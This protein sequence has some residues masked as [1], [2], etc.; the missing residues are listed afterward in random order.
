MNGFD[1][2]VARR[3]FLA[4]AVS[5]LA[6]LLGGSL[7]KALTSV[8]QYVARVGADVIRLANSGAPRPA[9]RNRFSSLV[10]RYANV[11][12]VALLAL[13]QYQ[14]LLPP[15]RREEFFRLVSNYIAAFFVSY[16]DDFRG[17]GFDIKSSVEEGRST[18]VD[19]QISFDGR[20]DVDV[21]WRITS[22]RV[23]DVKV[24]G[25]WLSLQ[26]KKRFTDILKRTRGDFEP[27]F[28]ELKSAESW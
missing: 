19:S 3:R 20:S 18:V 23:S 4:T 10:N 25:I 17:T 22:G 6:L 14:Q 12:G 8:E 26:L 21:R 13:G 28:D 11:R 27:L 16:L 24:K 9:L 2:P 5:V 15:N 1:R 7:A